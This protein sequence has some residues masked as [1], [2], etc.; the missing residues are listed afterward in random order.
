V[1]WRKGM[2]KVVRYDVK[3]FV[4]FQSKDYSGATAIFTKYATLRWE[5]PGLRSY[6]SG[7]RQIQSTSTLVQIKAGS[8]T[9][10]L[11][12]GF[13]LPFPRLLESSR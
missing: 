2:L 1:P 10:K 12:S 6:C 8:S 9:V 5:R 4:I 3:G 11:R 7:H 13:K